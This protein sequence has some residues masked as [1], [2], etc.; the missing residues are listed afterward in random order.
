VNVII[1]LGGPVIE[2]LLAPPL[3]IMPQERVLSAAV[4]YVFGA[5]ISSVL[6]GIVWGSIYADAK[7]RWLCN[8][9]DWLHG[10]LFAILPLIISV[11]MLMGAA[12]A[13]GSRPQQGWLLLS[14]GEAVRWGIYGVFLGL[15][16]PVFRARTQRP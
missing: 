11:T 8:L 4:L 3:R 7:L 12:I 9:P 16:Y 14:L 1:Y 15:I 2:S 10:P 5:S 6:L 13:L